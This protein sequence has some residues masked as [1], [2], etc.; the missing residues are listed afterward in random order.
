MNMLNHFINHELDCLS[1]MHA[2]G[3]SFDGPL[4]CDGK[5]HRFSMD[6]KK[7]QPDE[8]YRCYQGVS[9]KGNA[10]LNCYYGT[11]SGEQETFVYNSYEA[12]Q[13]IS[14]EE[15]AEIC[16][17]EVQRKKHLDQ[18]LQEEKKRRIEK[19]QE[20]WDQA[21]QDPTTKGHTSYLERKQIN[22]YGIKYR[23]DYQ[24]I[25]AVVIPLCNLDGQLQAVQCIQED[26]TKRIYGAKKGNFHV[27][28][29]IETQSPIFIAEGYATAASIHQATNS[30]VVV[31]FDCGN[32]KSVAH[33]LRKKYP[34]AK[35]I[36]A[37]DD[38]R[39][40]PGNPG[41]TKAEEAAKAYGCDVIIPIFPE[42]FVFSSNKYLTDF[43]DLHVH[44]GLDIAANQLRQVRRSEEQT[45]N[46]VLSIPQIPP[47]SF[48]FRSA[49]ALTREPPKA[50]WLIKSYIDACSFIQLFGEPGSMKSFLAIDM[51][52]CV[53]SGHNWHS[54]PIRKKGLVFYIAGE[55]FSGLSKRLKA[56]SLANNIDLEQI[57]FFCF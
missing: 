44:C 19:A 7:N 42:G 36:I 47:R 31:A 24:G 29:T 21:L 33:N 23:V 2:N 12:N 20:T 16:A 8:W 34:Q 6:A 46:S 25:P 15:Q 13:W 32:L 18:E 26:G 53:A 48:Q 35:L 22:A 41:K 10:Y 49:Y 11:W 55:G 50:N 52:L 51:G 39:E 17:K 30:P 56:W 57:P 28:G 3:I 37:A 45:K 43:N 54:S 5:L 14:Q 9:S 40:T 27:I 1:H 38:D 4:K